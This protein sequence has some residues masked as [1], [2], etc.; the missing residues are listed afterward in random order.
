MSIASH[1]L[2]NRRPPTFGFVGRL[3]DDKGMRT[4][5]A[6]FRL[7]RGRGSDARLIIA[8]TPDPANPAS[9]TKAEANP[10]TGSRASPGSATSRYC[11]LLGARACRG[12]A[13]A[14][15][16]P[17]VIADGGGG[18]RPRHDRERCAGLP[19][20]GHPRA[21]RPAISRRRCAGACGRQWRGSPASPNCARVMLGRRANLV[22]REIR[23]RYHWAP[24]RRII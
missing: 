24:N 4:L 18:M 9:V 23:R 15:R 8:G 13:V 11:R 3:L 12:A 7:L 22:G 14:P 5:V 6:A 17:A 20:S 21:N 19:R 16:R 10:G 2:P 1:R